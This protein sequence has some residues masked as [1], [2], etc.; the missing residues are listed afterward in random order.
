MFAM[1]SRPAC[2]L[3]LAC[4]VL[5]AGCISADPIAS[6]SG[7]GSSGGSGGSAVV[8]AGRRSGL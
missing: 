5:F 4:L 2:S 8:T 7:L 6:E 3:L 1:R